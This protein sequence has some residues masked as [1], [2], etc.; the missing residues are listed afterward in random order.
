MTEDKREEPSM[1]N[2]FKKTDYEH[3]L[4]LQHQTKEL[5]NLVKRKNNHI[6]ALEEQI[7]R[8]IEG[9]T[10]SMQLKALKAQITEN[11]RVI[12][13]YKDLYHEAISNK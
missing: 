11:Q 1:F 3:R 5:L 9:Y 13:K 2:F 6:K 4:F 12:K 8:I 10:E 7:G